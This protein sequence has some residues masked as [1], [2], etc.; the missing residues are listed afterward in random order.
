MKEGKRTVSQHVPENQSEHRPERKDCRTSPGSQVAKTALKP[1]VF[2]LFFLKEASC[3]Y[4]PSKK[5]WTQEYPREYL[6][7]TDH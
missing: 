1:L 7:K 2:S 5:H 3:A 4:H 6:L